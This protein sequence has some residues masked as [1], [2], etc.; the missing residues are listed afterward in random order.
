LKSLTHILLVIVLVFSAISPQE[1]YAQKKKKDKDEKQEISKYER[2][3]AEYLF[4]E[5]QK[6]FLLEDYERS[7][8]FLNK[9]L[10]IDPGNHAAYFKTAEIHLITE[11][12]TQ[13]LE[14]IAKATALEKENRYYYILAAQLHKAANNLEGAARQYELMVANTSNYK[15][16]LLDMVDI[17]VAL[18]DYDKALSTLSLTEKAYGTPGKF[19]L[20]KKELLLTA[21]KTGEAISYLEQ[22]L[23]EDPQNLELTEEYITL[24]SSSGNTPKAVSYLETSSS[25]IPGNRPMLAILYLKTGQR[26]Q[27]MPLIDQLMTSGTL[28]VASQLRLM[29]SL[30]EMVDADNVEATQRYMA[31]LQSRF[32]G[33]TDVLTLQGRLLNTVSQKNLS[34]ASTESQTIEVLAQLKESDPSNLQT[35]KKLLS[36]QYRQEDWKSLLENSEESLDYFPN[37]G[38]LYYYFASALLYTGDADEATDLLNQALRLSSRND[39]LKARIYGKQSEIAFEN[40]QAEQAESLYTKAVDLVNHPEIVNNYSFRLALHKID[41]EKALQLSTE[42]VNSHAEQLKYIRTRAFV[43]FQSANYAGAR[44]LL[45]ESFPKLEGQINGQA[46]ELYGDILIKLDLIDEA[47]AQWQKAKT[48]GNTSEKL[49]QKIANKEYF[50]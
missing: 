50:E 48:L 46:R 15:E 1:V 43:L 28:S 13:G 27:A 21:G 6:Y 24:L 9:S 29:E 12:Y 2:A 45:E 49:S 22:L 7:I 4:I 40:N 25:E 26:E 11:R 34:S 23:K 42:L 36:Y 14:A 3:N 47:V 31:Q 33:N 39:S 44:Q 38:I 30:I 37:Q 35:W 18:E 5:A 20:Q 41:L 19:A 32:P 8:T 17:Y 10:E 16:F